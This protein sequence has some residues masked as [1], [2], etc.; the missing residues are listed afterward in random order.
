MHVTLRPVQDGDEPFLLRVY[1]GTRV[2]EL[3]P[4]PWTAEQKA[5]FVAQQFAAQTAH[6]AQHYAR[7]SADVIVIDDAPAG[8]LLVDRRD[9]AILIVDISLLPE[10]RGRGAGSVLLRDVLGEATAAEK[11]VVIHVERF[12]RALRLYERLGFLAVGDHGVYLRMEWDPASRDTT[13]RPTA[14]HRR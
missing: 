14:S 7:M 13:T 2:E 11:R 6:Y 1:A 3:A 8:R 10:H 12:N 4:L 5:A 9:D